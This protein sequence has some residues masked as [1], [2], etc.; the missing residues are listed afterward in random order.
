MVETVTYVYRLWLACP[1]FDR[2]LP[3][4]FLYW[5]EAV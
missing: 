2:L 5:V 3:G 4:C 1:H